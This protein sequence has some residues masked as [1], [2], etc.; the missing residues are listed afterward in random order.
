MRI[1]VTCLLTTTF[2]TF[3][4][5]ALA[6]QADQGKKADE[7]RLIAA[8]R[9]VGGS[10]G[11]EPLPFDKVELKFTEEGKVHSREGEGRLDILT[12]KLPGPGQ[13]DFIEK[14]TFPGIYKF[15]GE[16]LLLCIAMSPKD[17]RPTEFASPKGSKNYYWILEKVKSFE[18]MTPAEK[19]KVEA[20]AMRTNSANNLKQIGVA[21]HTYH[22]YNKF[23]P[24]HAIYSKDDKTPLLSWRVAILPYLEQQTLY[25]Q[26]KLD[27]P[28]D[29]EHNK[30][31][32]PLMPKVYAAAVESKKKEGMTYW[33][34]FTGQDCLFDGPKK[35][36][37]IQ[38]VG[39]GL[40]NTIMVIEGAEPVFWT[41]PADLELPKAGGKMP[42]L[43][44]QFPDFTHVVMCDSAV[45]SFR[46]DLD[47][48]IL[49]ALVTPNGREE[50]DWEKVEK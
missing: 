5:A 22:D 12:Y 26:F 2:V 39:D 29:S 31:L 14:E 16:K 37:W 23:V 10:M 48:A 28:W 19:A 3:M 9:V 13:I 41:K 20:A 42:A 25:E 45:H 33:Q 24:L 15:D 17:K 44:G 47:P 8:W 4:G 7:K 43:G 40:S 18:E 1:S 11:G 35:M 36:K 34:V 21:F 46:R 32:I 38:S 27:Q 6:S 30:K 50:I 49:R